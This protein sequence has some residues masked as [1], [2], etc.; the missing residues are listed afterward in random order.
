MKKHCLS[1]SYGQNLFVSILFGYECDCPYPCLFFLCLSLTDPT[2][3]QFIDTPPPEITLI[4]VLRNYF[5]FMPA[6]IG[7]MV[8]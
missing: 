1:Y 7:G 5:D 2:Y 3:T 8:K 4:N 6:Y